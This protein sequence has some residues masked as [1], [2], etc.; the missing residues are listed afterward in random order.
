MIAYIREAPVEQDFLVAERDRSVEEVR[1]AQILVRRHCR[2][3]GD[4]EAFLNSLSKEL[5]ALTDLALVPGEGDV[6]LDTL[7]DE[8]SIRDV[9]GPNYKV[10]SSYF[11]N[12]I[13]K[14]WAN[15]QK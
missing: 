11:F 1:A 8:D 2:F 4:E 9:C 5:E 3:P 10:V 15:F 12:L 13:Q 7:T 14:P 6:H